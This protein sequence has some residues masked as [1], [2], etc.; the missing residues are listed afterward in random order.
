MKRMLS[1]LL[2]AIGI[3]AV[4]AV[5]AVI[6]VTTFLDPEDLKPELEEVVKER[7]GLILDLKGPLSW[8]FYPRLGVGVEQAEAWLPEQSIEQD[9]A[10]MAFRRA[11]VSLAFTSLLRGEMA[12]DGM[13][14]DGLRL[15]LSRD[16]RG[17]G[18]WETL[19]ERLADDDEDLPTPASAS[20]AP[21]PSGS[22]PSVAFNIARVEVKDGEVNYTDQAIGRSL[23]LKGLSVTGRNVNPRRP[24]P[25]TTSFQLFGHDTPTGAGDTVP[26]LASDVT[27]QGRLALALAERRYSLEDLSLV[28][29]NQLAGVKSPQQLEL[30][31]QRLVIDARE[32]QLRLERGT[33]NATLEHAVLGEAP[34]SLVMEFALESDIADG[35]AQLHDLTLSGN[36]GL[37]L[38][39]NLNLA[40][41]Y[42]EPRYDGQLRLAPTSLR[43]WL[44]R[45]GSLPTTA[46]PEAFSDVAL[47]TP[48]EGDLQQVAL[49]GMTLVLDDSTFTGRLTAGL[50]GQSLEAELQGDS[51]NLDAYLPAASGTAP[52]GAGLWSPGIGRAYAQE[53]EM[54]PVDWLRDLSLDASLTLSQLR[55]GGLD[56]QDASLALEGE[57]GRL[58]LA[59]LES[60][61]YEGSLAATGELDLT[62]DPIAWRLA[63]R[64]ERVR[65]DTLLEALG[66]GDARAPLR[67]QAFVD[68][69]L[70][71]HGNA[72]PVM[73]RGLNGRLATRLGD[74]AI[75]DVNVSRE[76]CSAVAT[77]QGE[78]TQREWAPDTRFE[79]AEATLEVRDGV[80]ES[81]D[82]VVTLPGIDVGGEGW[83]DLT[84]ERFDLRAA[85]RVVDTADM[86]CKVNRRLERLPLPVRCEG[87]LDG[88]SAE[89]CRF[90]SNGFQAAIGEALRDELGERAGN[91]V[92]QQL[93]G[94]LDKLEERLGEG[95]GKELRDSLRGLF[96]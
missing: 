2:A 1:T 58:R 82:L 19:L 63:P 91:A 81:D 61:F 95:A 46:D 27:L 87:S 5:G 65:V 34:L 50:D 14:L 23:H 71:T 56:F 9:M 16:E 45:F 8:S 6:Y 93:E 3:L 37:R 39:G 18:N 54:L 49:S 38:S 32:R 4:L 22:G 92:E 51:L 21:T 68:G 70:T 67:G 89:W 83:L 74:G 73:K 13:A 75:L 31:G 29:R 35:S 57:D 80:V 12:I 53:G 86:A 90:D 77:L 52:D 42:D 15:N 25:F 24:F 96:E 64:L 59:S 79:R 28:T 44:E 72:W 85:A 40:A 66:E 76:L 43:P 17:R 94:A 78:T 33:L 10:F 41:L 69:E 62:R 84:S 60:A 55:L 36:D 30:S 7:T 20:T 26:K 47:T 48:L 11:E 88:D